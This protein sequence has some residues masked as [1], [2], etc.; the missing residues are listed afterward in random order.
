MSKFTFK[1][2]TEEGVVTTKEI[3]ADVWFDLIPEFINF[4]KGCG[5]GLE[6]NSIGVNTNRHSPQNN[7][8]TFCDEEI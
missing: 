5:F 4:L 6:D 1:R 2:E 7:V 3:D 8:A